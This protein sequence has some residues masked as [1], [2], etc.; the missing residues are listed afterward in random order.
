KS[1]RERLTR[2]EAAAAGRRD[3]RALR[4]SLDWVEHDDKGCERIL[5]AL[6]AEDGKDATPEREVGRHLCELY[7]FAEGLPFARRAA[8][9]DENDWEAWKELGRALANTGDE[10]GAREALERA[11][12]EAAGRQDA[13]RDN[14][15]RV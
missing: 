8:Q 6:A 12:K 15:R 7:R 2:L 1:A 13:W 3:V 5:S 10:G 9:R 4:A 14:V 11:R